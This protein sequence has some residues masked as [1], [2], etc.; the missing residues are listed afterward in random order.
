MPRLRARAHRPGQLL[1]AQFGDGCNHGNAHR[2]R[3]AHRLPL[4]HSCTTDCLAH[5]AAS[6]TL[7]LAAEWHVGR[8]L[9]LARRALT[10]AATPSRAPPPPPQC[11]DAQFDL[12]LVISQRHHRGGTRRQR[13]MALSLSRN[14]ESLNCT[15]LHDQRQGA[16]HTLRPLHLCAP[17]LT[18]Q[19]RR[20]PA[21]SSSQCGDR[22]RM[23]GP[24]QSRASRTQCVT[25][26]LKGDPGGNAPDLRGGSA[27]LPV[28]TLR[29]A[30]QRHA[31]RKM[32]W[33]RD[34]D[35]TMARR[36]SSIAAA[37]RWPVRDVRRHRA[38]LFSRFLHCTRRQPRRRAAAAA[39]HCAA[40]QSQ[41]GPPP[42][43][44]PTAGGGVAPPSWR[45]RR[46]ARAPHRRVARLAR[47]VAFH[48]TMSAALSVSCARPA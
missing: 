5:A 10:A 24:S 44:D 48:R 4:L 33:G 27:T 41:P 25:Q 39:P 36:L 34:T 3:A 18:L 2:A 26:A 19:R 15:T 23:Q 22:R 35:C 45:K 1:L 31:T 46:S 7:Q 37:A 47:D 30:C 21:A 43:D 13:S 17:P 6:P 38:P 29:S 11:A 9:L 28:L 8:P 32:H 40:P 12:S 16:A 42:R 14:S 20:R